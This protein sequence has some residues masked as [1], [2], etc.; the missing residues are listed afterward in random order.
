MM[1]LVFG[2][3]AYVTWQFASGTWPSTAVTAGEDLPDF[4]AELLAENQI[5]EPGEEI[6]YFYSLALTNYL[7]DGNVLTDRRVIRYTMDEGDLNVTAATFA[8]VLLIE[9]EYPEDALGDT[10]LKVQSEDELIYL[11]LSTE[12]ERDRAFIEELERRVARED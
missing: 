3:A 1:A 11:F 5:L 9:P 4:V 10:S 6:L 12:N 2:L 8:E 7:D